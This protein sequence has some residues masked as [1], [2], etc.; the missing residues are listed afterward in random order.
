[1]IVLLIAVYLPIRILIGDVVAPLRVFRSFFFGET[2]ISKGWYLQVQLFLYLLF[3]LIWR[4][5]NRDD[6]KQLLLIAFVSVHVVL[7]I[8]FDVAITRYIS[9]PAFNLG[10]FW[11]DKREA[12]F[13]KL[14]NKKTYILSFCVCFFAM[15]ATFGGWYFTSG[16]ISTLSQGICQ[17]LFVVLI[18]LAVQKIKIAN[19]ITTHLGV[20]SLEIYIIQGLFLNMY[21]SSLICIENDCIFAGA[22]AV[23]TYLAALVLH[24]IIKLI[25]SAFGDQKIKEQN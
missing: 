24:P 12:I 13:A 18:I 14:K 17:L 3:F 21:K 4:F 9:L 8:C 1:M 20:Y 22:V 6:I 11:A 2:I 25:Y 7:C 10:I 15:G 16:A 19:L 5:V 23:S